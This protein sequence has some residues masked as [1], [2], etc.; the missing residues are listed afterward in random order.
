MDIDEIRTDTPGC[1]KVAHLNNAGA[2]LPPRP[3][4]DAV[5]GHFAQESTIGA[6]EAA[7]QNQAAID[8]FYGAVARLLGARPDEIA[9]VEN[10]TRA[11]D[12]AFY[13]IPFADGDRIL[14]TTSEYSSN[15]IAYQ[16]VAAATGA[17]V[18][19][20]PDE[21][22]GTLSLDALEAELAKGNVRLVSLNHVPTH[23]GLVNP[24]AEVGR[25]CRE[26]GVL[27]LLDACQSVG[28]LTVDVTEIGCD[29]LSATGRKFLRG[30][31]GTGFLYVRR[32]ILRTLVPP[33]LDLQ[34]ATWKAPDGFEMR[35]DAQRFETW[36]RYV[37]G[38]IGLGVAADY[39]ADLGM[40]QI[41][42]RVL[43]L[44]T[45]LRERLA[46]RP[47]VTVLDKGA[48]PSGIVTFT[49]DGHDPAAIQAAA[50]ARGVNVN[51]TNPNTHG[52]DPNA[53]QAAVR[54]SVHYYNTE[55]ELEQLLSAL[56]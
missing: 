39:A 30:P 41:Q 47:G 16:Q 7:D 55:G 46:G 42:E 24:A 56:P 49:V 14:T 8:R 38:Q 29:M 3:V 33:F 28:Q 12:L 54:A 6:Y 52:Y 9:Y 36:E 32:D 26:H 18:E 5:A 27:Y 48:R 11:W 53:A 45:G 20:V 19:V 17:R 10:A 43:N 34:A 4:I 37:A 21:S 35:D 23:N 1:A 44:A 31:R 25:L 40:P 15:A 13:S 2:A 22:D 51:V 50:K